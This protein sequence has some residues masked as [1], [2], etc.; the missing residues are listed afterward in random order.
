MACYGDS[1]TFYFYSANYTIPENV[2]L[3]TWSVKQEHHQPC[4][5]ASLLGL[6][7]SAGVQSDHPFGSVVELCQASG[8]LQAQQWGIMWHSMFHDTQT[9][10][11]IDLIMPF[12]TWDLTFSYLRPWTLLF[13]V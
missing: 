7:T 5:E 4:P 1:F 6:E 2:I 9:Q 3:T 11:K 10:F 8:T 13:F 12:C